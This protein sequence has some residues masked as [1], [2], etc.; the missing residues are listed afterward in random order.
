[1]AIRIKDLLKLILENIFV[2]GLKWDVQAKVSLLELIRL[3]AMMCKP[4][5]MEIK[6]FTLKFLDNSRS[7]KNFKLLTLIK[8]SRL[9]PHMPK[10]L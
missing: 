3:K 9:F 4:Q 8:K 5:E 7:V 6:I 10:K 1:M 2:E